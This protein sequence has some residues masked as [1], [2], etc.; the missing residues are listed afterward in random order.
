MAQSEWIDSE[1]STGNLV[2]FDTGSNHYWV[3][4]IERIIET[5]AANSE[6]ASD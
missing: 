2:T 1:V 4:D 5:S 3:F 6:S